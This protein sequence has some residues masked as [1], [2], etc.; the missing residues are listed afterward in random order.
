MT[1]CQSHAS[2]W[3]TAGDGGDKKLINSHL[4][5]LFLIYWRGTGYES[6]V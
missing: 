4:Y 6:L 5:Y 2:V 1:S 3:L